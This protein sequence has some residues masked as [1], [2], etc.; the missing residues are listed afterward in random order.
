MDLFYLVSQ[1]EAAL[2]LLVLLMVRLFDIRRVHPGE[3]EV[4]TDGRRHHVLISSAN[5][6]HR[7]QM[8]LG[9]HSFGVGG[10]P[11]KTGNL[12]LPLLIRLF[13]KE[14]VFAVSLAFA[15]E[16]PL[17]IFLGLVFSSHIHFLLNFLNVIDY[18]ISGS[19]NSNM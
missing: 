10:R 11:E 16:S 4:L 12:G 18:K 15:G 1:L 19:F 3:L 5:G 2:R 17:E 9:M 6:I 8:V 14:K 13:G 7:V